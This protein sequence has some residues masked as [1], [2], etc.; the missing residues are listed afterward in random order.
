MTSLL[1]VKFFT[2]DVVILLLFF[3]VTAVLTPTRCSACGSSSC[4]S[5]NSQQF[6]NWHKA[7]NWNDGKWISAYNTGIE[8]YIRVENVI[9]DKSL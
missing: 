5:R 9:N 3:E 2:A 4:V 6:Y 8:F 1:L 7:I